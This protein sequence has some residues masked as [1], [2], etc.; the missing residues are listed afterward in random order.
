MDAGEPKRSRRRID[1]S[2]PH[3]HWISISLV[4][5]PLWSGKYFPKWFPEPHNADPHKVTRFS[6][7]HGFVRNGISIKTLIFNVLLIF[8][9]T[10][11]CRDL[12]G[13]P[14]WFDDTDA[15]FISKI[16]RKING[17]WTH[18]ANIFCLDLSSFSSKVLDLET[19]VSAARVQV[20]DC[21]EYPSDPSL[22]V[23]D[24]FENPTCFKNAKIAN[25]LVS[26][27]PSVFFWVR[28]Q[29]NSMNRTAA[30]GLEKLI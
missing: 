7:V 21:P 27:L 11:R 6:I 9:A 8:A 28:F 16:D 25:P 20:I 29:G 5:T 1:L 2:P 14:P 10:N 17:P 19:P 22:K 24:F 3:C 4:L 15:E 30:S 12:W 18:K 26:A 13:S 23:S